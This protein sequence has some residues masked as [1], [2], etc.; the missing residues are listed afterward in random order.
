MNGNKSVFVCSSLQCCKWEKT[1]SRKSGDRRQLGTVQVCWMLIPCGPHSQ[2]RH[3][4][5]SGGG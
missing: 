3:W 1:C 5:M 4:M 2:W